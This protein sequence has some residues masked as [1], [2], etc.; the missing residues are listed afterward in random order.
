[1][2]RNSRNTVDVIALVLLLFLIGTERQHPF[3]LTEGML[4]NCKH[5]RDNIWIPPVHRW[6]SLWILFSDWIGCGEKYKNNDGSGIFDDIY[7]NTLLFIETISLLH[8]DT[9]LEYGWPTIILPCYVYDVCLL[10]SDWRYMTN[11][12][13]FHLI[14]ALGSWGTFFINFMIIIILINGSIYIILQLYGILF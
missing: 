5:D 2:N 8:A 10:C 6:L 14:L 7:L 9:I 1:M 13:Q 12:I 11:T 4:Q 3:Q